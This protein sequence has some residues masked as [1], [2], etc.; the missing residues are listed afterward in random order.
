MNCS[1]SRTQQILDICLQMEAGK[2]MV[3]ICKKTQLAGVGGGG[4]TPAPPKHS[5]NGRDQGQALD[6]CFGVGQTR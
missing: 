2:C 3:S 4:G 6:L 1:C 5:G